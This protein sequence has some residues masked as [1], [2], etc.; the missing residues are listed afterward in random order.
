MMRKVL[1]IIC[2]FF[3]IT[4]QGQTSIFNKIR[5][6]ELESVDTLNLNTNTPKDFFL[7]QQ[8][9]YLASGKLIPIITFKKNHLNN[10][11]LFYSY[12]SRA[13]YYIFKES[14]KFSDSMAYSNYIK[15]LNIAKKIDNDTLL[16]ETYKRILKYQY[17]NQKDIPEFHSMAIKY[18]EKAYDINERLYSDFF[19]MGS[20][21]G[22]MAFRDDFDIDPV[23]IGLNN[24]KISNDKGLHFFSGRFA[25]SLGVYYYEFTTRKDSS[26]FYYKQAIDSYKKETYYYSMKHLNDI[27][28]NLGTVSHHNKNYIQASTY[29][30]KIDVTY[31]EKKDG[32]DQLLINDAIYKNFKKMNQSDSALHYLERKME[33]TNLVDETNRANAISELSKKYN[34]VEKEKQLL[35]SEKQNKQKQYLLFGLAGLLILVG[36]IATLINRI[37]KRKQRIAEQ[38]REIEI[39]KTETLLKEQE[40]TTLDAMIAGQEKERQRLAGDLHDNVGATLAAARLQFEHL[41]NNRNKTEITDELF[42]KTSHLLNDA[43]NEIRNI[44][45]V[46]NSGVIAKNGLLPAVQ[47]LASNASANG[48]L[49]IEVSHFGLENRIENSLEITLFRVIQELVTNII[50]HSKA[51]EASIAIT[52]HEGVINVIIEDN[53]IGIS[54]G[55]KLSKSNGMG[56]GNIEKRIEFIDGTFE[57][58]TSPGKGTTIIIDVPAN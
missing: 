4:I 33:I 57:I 35:I 15:S 58:D 52:Q 24:L 32:R 5:T 47:K 38:E 10:E 26:E 25:Q 44:S 20:I 9:H 11:Q 46:K 34:I 19:Y 8:Y 39:Q 45:H 36:I 22:N 29:F 30:S 3:Y 56:I 53:G 40:L 6:F 51:S 54:E 17:K 12:L 7:M 48:K 27:H 50:K 21:M 13:E 41:K 28:Y 16:C 18:Q 42:T 1:F 55:K 2:L 37:T 31:I 49:L 23:P 14:N 43:Y